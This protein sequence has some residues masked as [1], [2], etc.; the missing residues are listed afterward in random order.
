MSVLSILLW[1]IPVGKGHTHKS[2]WDKFSL[3]CEILQSH[4]RIVITTAQCK[5][6]LYQPVLSLWSALPQIPPGHTLKSFML[7]ENVSTGQKQQTIGETFSG[8]LYA[9]SA[10]NAQPHKGNWCPVNES[11]KEMCP[12]GWLWGS[13]KRFCWF[14]P[15]SLCL[16]LLHHDSMHN[17]NLD[18]EIQKFHPTALQSTRQLGPQGHSREK[19]SSRISAD[20]FADV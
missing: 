7:G 14:F 18:E 8:G 12:S 5:S 3:L 2:L 19:R 20:K 10:F 11:E 1:L 9:P 16:D 4:Q 15:P 13:L 6:Q 17:P